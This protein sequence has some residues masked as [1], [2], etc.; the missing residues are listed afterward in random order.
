MISTYKKILM[1]VL[2]EQMAVLRY[3]Q[4]LLEAIIALVVQAIASTMITKDVMVS[5]LII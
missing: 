4:T 1:N 3:V 2:R 5:H